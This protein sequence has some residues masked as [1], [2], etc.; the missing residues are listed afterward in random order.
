VG[1]FGG[2]AYVVF[3]QTA[4]AVI[5]L[6][7]I[8]NGNGGFAINGQAAYDY[9]GTAV[10][11]AGDV[12]GDGLSDLLLGVSS[13]DPATGG[14]AGRTYVVF[15]KTS[16]TAIN[17]SDIAGGTGG[18]VING[19]SAGEYSGYSVSTAGDVNGDGLADLIVGADYSDPSAGTDAGRSYVVF[20]KSANRTEI[21]LSA[22]TTGTSTEGFVINGQCAGDRSGFSVSSAG[23]VN[24]DGL[25]DLIL[26]ALFGD[27]SGAVDGGR[28]YLVYGK[29]GSSAIDL[30]AVANG[31]GGFVINGQFAGDISGYSVSAAGDVNGDGL[32]DL[33][34]GAPGSDPTGAVGGGR[35]YV[36][37]GNTN[38]AFS[39]TYVDFM[40][41]T[42]AE[43]LTG[44]TAAETFAA[45]QGNDTLIG[46]GGADVMWGGAGN[47]TF[48]V[49]TSNLTALQ[50]VFGAGGNTAQLSRV[51]GGTGFDTL[52]LAQGSGNLDLTSIKNAGGAAPDGLSRIDSIEIIDL[53][54]DTAA[55]TL[56]LTVKDVIDM[57][58]MNLFNTSNTVAVSGTSLGSSVA[59]HQLMITGGSE[60]Y[61]NIG[62]SNWT[63]STTV[64]TY[65]GR[66]YKVYNANSSVAAQ[67]LIDQSIVNNAG[68]VL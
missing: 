18:F 3:G 9:M 43:T 31:S 23:D 60:D 41:T 15:G 62:T 20:G 66:T 47:D 13:S 21:N 14:A 44:T 26:G 65:G 12:N 28:S 56:T 4:N 27:P 54:T 64:L 22:L 1:T 52:Q 38:G 53:A 49:N 33:I 57:S 61:A 46:G 50:N 5:Q 30:T 34:V 55:N 58:G 35:S 6:S 8:A 10:S 29:T 2:R 39:N 36:I 48:T 25:A 40:G 24:G 68:H 7:A 17:A 42:S 63:L 11:N 45:G 59:K 16:G 67:L 19:L 51:L 37:F 32:A